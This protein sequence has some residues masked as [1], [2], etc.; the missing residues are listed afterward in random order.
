MLFQN[1][2]QI[3]ATVVFFM[4]FL[5]SSVLFSQEGDCSD[6]LDGPDADGYIDCDD[7]DCVGDPACP[8]VATIT[9]D[10]SYAFGFGDYNGIDPTQIYGCF[11]AS[12]AG[13]IYNGSCADLNTYNS[14]GA[15][16]FNLSGSLNGAYIYMV[17]WADVSTYQGAIAQFSDS[18]T[19]LTSGIINGGTGPQWEVFATGLETSPDNTGHCASG[20][21][22]LLNDVNAQVALANGYPAAPISNT[23][24][25]G[26]AASPGWVGANGAVNGLHPNDAGNGSVLHFDPFPNGNPAAQYPNDAFSTPVGSCTH[27]DNPE[28][29]W[30]WYNPDANSDGLP[31]FTSPFSTSSF[32][33]P[34]GEYLIFRVGPLNELFSGCKTENPRVLCD[35][36]TPGVDYNLTF[37]VVNNTG[38]D[39]TKLVIPGLV[40]G[41]SISPNIINLPTP[42]PS[43]STAT[44]IS[45]S[46]TGGTAGST[47]CIPVGLIAE[48]AD[49]NEFQCCGTEVCVELPNCCLLISEESLTF[50]A[51]GNLIYTFTLTNGEGEEPVTAEHLFMEVISPGGVTVSQEWQ[52]LNGLT[53]NSSILLSTQ[54]VGATPGST[55][56]FD[57][58]IHDATLN[59]CCG[60]THCVIIPAAEPQLC[61]PDISCEVVADT[62][63]LQFPIPDPLDCC[64]SDILVLLDGQQ[65]GSASPTAGSV[66]VPCAD[67]VYCLACIDDAG[68]L[69]IQACCDVSCFPLLPPAVHFIRG[70]SNGDG[71]LNIADAVKTLNF[72]FHSAVISCADALDAND[73]ESVNIA[74]AIFTLEGL[75]GSTSTPWPLISN[76]GID[77][78]D[79]P[80]ECDSFPACP[81]N[82]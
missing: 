43:G 45:V 29:T 34:S 16:R 64:G 71:A 17:C 65:I 28:A 79:G 9:V 3:L 36:E 27:F 50:D 60:V 61:I 23:P 21:T 30:M 70:D 15:E 18:V 72:L 63:V 7:E 5:G 10:N 48:D 12:Q 55:V 68:N 31:D 56:C 82:D 59:T 6:G 33:T 20:L 76:C 32:G 78:T 2:C 22:A 24:A 42:L 40:G 19:S 62:V 51:A 57:I 37:D 35:T 39:V 52:P 46:I 54:I 26:G 74:D 13:D 53:D 58:T 80:L 8:I 44:G 1:R 4:S 81:E 14:N 73:D 66:T 69:V 75:F 38:F 25:N 67:G 11:N 47:L 49:G 41:A 77:T